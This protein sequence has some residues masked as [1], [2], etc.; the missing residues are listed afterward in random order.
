MII[1]HLERLTEKNWWTVGSQ[2][3]IDGAKSSDEV[4]GWG[5]KG[6]YVYQKCFVEFFVEKVD[7]ERIEM[8]IRDKGLGWID[9]FAASDDVRPLH[10]RYQ[11]VADQAQD[12]FRTN[13]PEGGRNAVTWGVFPGQEVAQSTIIE[14]ASFL[15][16]KVLACAT[17]Q[18]TSLTNTSF[19]TR[20][21]PFGQTG[22][23]STHQGLLNG[24][25]WTAFGLSGGWSA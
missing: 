9:Y 10:V 11:Y 24:S 14:K 1:R 3:A 22:H 25:C 5:P 12:E 18:D 20:P 21:F 4:V 7:V 6:G 15:A 13:V 2:P 23:R 8:K 16:W 17:L 19:R